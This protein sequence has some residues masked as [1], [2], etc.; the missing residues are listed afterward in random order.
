MR[1]FYSH[2]YY[3]NIIQSH[4]TISYFH[5]LPYPYLAAYAASRRPDTNR[6]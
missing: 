5:R 1:F 6:P 3:S 4:A 2:V